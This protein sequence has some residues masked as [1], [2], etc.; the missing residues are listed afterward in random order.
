VVDRS[1]DS[2]SPWPV[3]RDDPG[4]E[5][6]REAPPRLEPAPEFE[7]YQILDELPRGG[8]AL[9]FKAVHKAT[10]SKVA[11]KVLPPGQLASAKARHLFEREVDLISALEHPNI[12]HIRDSGIAG[13]QYYFAMEY[14]RGRPLDQHVVSAKL[15]L[16]PTM[17]L[18]LKVCEAV[19]HAHRRGVIHRDLKPSNILVDEYGEPHL[20]DFG[21]AKAAGRMSDGLSMLSIT[22]E[23]KGTLSY[24][25]PEQASGRSDVVDTRSDVYSLGVVFYQVLTHEFPYDITGTTIQTLHH[26]QFTDP[27]R[28]RDV[29]GKFDRDLETI[30]LKTLAKDPA[31]RYDS[32]AELGDDIRRWQQG[33]PIHAR[34]SAFYILRKLARKHALTSAALVLGLLAVIV[35][36]FLCTCGYLCSQWRTARTENQRLTAELQRV[37]DSVARLDDQLAFNVVLNLWQKGRRR[38]AE[39]MCV[40]SFAQQDCRER[41]ALEFLLEDRPLAEKEP[42]FRQEWGQREPF[43]TTLVIAEHYLRD[44]DRATALRLFRQCLRP[45]Q[46]RTDVVLSYRVQ[47]RI[48]E[49]KEPD[50]GRQAGPPAPGGG[51]EGGPTP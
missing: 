26:I 16:G 12:V 37:N 42:A 40:G 29:L 28:P 3:S 48:V 13:G 35:T 51:P 33:L 31:E 36:S 11:L 45:G 20:L 19:A 21:L 6:T 9:V 49:L 5:A 1:N 47:D 4:D 44:K 2:T 30:L 24:M 32:A 23:I 38:E 22:G 18:L 43:F 25:S 50:E 27:V 41:R 46:V 7:G 14:I 17:E 34:T 39:S 8:Q 10:K 15:P